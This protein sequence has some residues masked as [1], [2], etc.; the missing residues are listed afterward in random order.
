MTYD[1]KLRNPNGANFVQYRSTSKIL[2][3]KQNKKK[4][5]THT[6]RYAMTC[7]GLI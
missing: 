5:L 6:T 2:K 7:K 1:G 3:K 4:A